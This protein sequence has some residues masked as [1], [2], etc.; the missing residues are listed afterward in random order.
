MEMEYK[1][2][3]KRG[4]WIIVLGLILAIAAAGGAFYL[5]NQAQQTAGQ[6]EIKTMT[7]VVAAKPLPAKKTLAPEDLLVRTDIPLDGTNS[8]GGMLATDP[9]QLIGRILGVDVAQG[10]LMTLN[11]LASTSVG[12]QFPILG[13]G[14]TVA[15]D[16][17]AWRAVS[18]TVSDDHAV[19]GMLTAGMTV[20]VLMSLTIAPLPSGSAAPTP[21]PD[22]NGP[23]PSASAGVNPISGLSTKVTYQ[24]MTILAR[25]GTYYVLKATLPVAEEI[26][27][28]TTDGA[29]FTLLLRPDQD[30]RVLDVSLLGA[31]TS[32]I[33]ERYGL[34][35]PLPYVSTGSNPPI[36]PITPPPSEA[37]SD[38]APSSAAPS[39]APSA[40]PTQ[41][42]TAA[43]TAS[44]S[45]APSLAPSASASGG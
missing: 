30:T 29:V 8:L 42:P 43:P 18:V 2:P 33:L 31:T 36:P 22:P 6:G 34:L 9:K 21:T 12:G 32:R 35:I 28:A 16:S 24:K 15:P 27:Q 5:I 39:V 3:S 14:E 4:R 19:G 10:Q 20:D 7:A 45:A 25:Q 11:L 40:A 44:P 37:P 23:R 17:D 13:P 26:T 41:A 1:D 38:A